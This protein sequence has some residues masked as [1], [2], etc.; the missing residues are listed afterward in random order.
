M[1]LNSGSLQNYESKPSV[2]NRYFNL[3]I[4]KLQFL[5]PN[6]IGVKF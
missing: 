5:H 1:N 4:K 3:K 6:V 2:K